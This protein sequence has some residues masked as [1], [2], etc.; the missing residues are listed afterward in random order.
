MHWRWPDLRCWDCYSSIFT[1]QLWPLVI[2]KFGFHSVFWEQIDGIWP[3]LAYTLILTGLGSDCYASISAI[4]NIQF[5]RNFHGWK[6]YR[7]TDEEASE[8]FQIWDIHTFHCNQ[9]KVYDFLKFRSILKSNSIALFT[10]IIVK[11]QNELYDYCLFYSGFM[12]LSAIFQSYR[13]GVLMWQGAQCSL[14]EDCL[15]EIS[16][17]RHLTWYS[18]HTHYT[19]TELTECDS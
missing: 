12:S 7:K 9:M 8:R 19:D 3:S 18:T 17:L 14:L 6:L 16:R 4:L 1:T 5:W 11:T 15:T 13:D 10:Y 2:V